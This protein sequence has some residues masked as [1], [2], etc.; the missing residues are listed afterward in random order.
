MKNEVTNID[1]NGPRS[2][3]AESARLPI[4]DL[5]FTADGEV[6]EVDLL[7]FTHVL[8]VPVSEDIWPGDAAELF[9]GK[10]FATQ[11]L[12]HDE[13]IYRFDNGVWE[14]MREEILR[15]CDT[16][17]VR[18]LES[19]WAAQFIVDDP[20]P[21]WET[22]WDEYGHQF[23][24]GRDDDYELDTLDSELLLTEE[25]IGPEKLDALDC[26]SSNVT[27]RPYR[28]VGVILPL[29]AQQPTEQE[30]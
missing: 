23:C 13:G 18:S 17:Q 12:E 22:H 24:D 7:A 26:V 4:L 2:Y 19:I 9:F 27:L 20:M 14:H 5:V 15:Q 29:D 16:H 6:T 21:D 8:N 1:I 28:R 25:Y 11:F 30:D 3:G 10:Y